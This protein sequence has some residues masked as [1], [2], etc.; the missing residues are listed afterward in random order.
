MA[1]GQVTLAASDTAPGLQS[2]IWSST[3][4]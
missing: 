3:G 4:V 1:L 2:C